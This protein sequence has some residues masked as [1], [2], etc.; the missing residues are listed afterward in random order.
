VARLRKNIER[1]GT[2]PAARGPQEPRNHVGV[3]KNVHRYSHR[4]SSPSGNGASRISSG[5]SYSG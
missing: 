2:D 3:E 1:R 5:I 4:A